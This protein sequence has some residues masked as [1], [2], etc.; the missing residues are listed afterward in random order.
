MT[1]NNGT[2]AGVA[3]DSAQQSPQVTEAVTTYYYQ[4]VAVAS[5]LGGQVATKS[6]P[7]PNL[8]CLSATINAASSPPI[9][10]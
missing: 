3:S 10:A 1:D 9:S 8:S 4:A 5:S 2:A 7:A 6:V